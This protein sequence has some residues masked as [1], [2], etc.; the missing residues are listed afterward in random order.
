MP[1]PRY[2]FAEVVLAGI[3]SIFIALV[4]AAASRM[5]TPGWQVALG[6]G[7]WLNDHGTK[8]DIRLVVLLGVGL[9][10]LLC[11]AIIWIAHRWWVHHRGR[12]KS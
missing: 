1:Q 3:L 12:S 5:Y 11:F 4:A 7:F 2:W 6:L 10:S 8:L 9:D